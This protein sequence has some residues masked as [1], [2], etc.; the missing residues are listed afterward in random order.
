MQ[1]HR[2]H[3]F[4]TTA[5][6]LGLTG[7][8]TNDE[9]TDRN[10]KENTT[11][12]IGYY[13]NEQHDRNGGNA[14]LIDGND[15]DGPGVEI[16][17]HTLGAEAKDRVNVDKIRPGNGAIGDS[18]RNYHGH[19]GRN[20]N[21]NWDNNKTGNDTDNYS[22]K[23]TKAVK[24]VENVKDAQTVVY[25]DTVIIGV[26]LNKEEQSQQTEKKVQQVV[27]R[28]VNG[29]SIKVMANESQYNRLKVINNDQRN[30][31]PKDQIND[32]LEN[33]IQSNQN[34]D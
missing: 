33:L 6:L 25:R 31:G 28:Y 10:Q 29:K 1:Q 2:K 26:L 20:Q 24:D 5:L 27:K 12:P 23:I 13:S 17:D 18:D 32:D 30:S 9:A 8:G 22:N 7:C 21:V 14:T 16:M 15:N 3:W 11:L 19:L 4:L 34:N